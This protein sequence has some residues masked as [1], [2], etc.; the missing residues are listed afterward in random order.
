MDVAIISTLLAVLIATGQ[1]SGGQA[2]EAVY[3]VVLQDQRCGGRGAAG[4]RGDRPVLQQERVNPAAQPWW[5]FAPPPALEER[6]PTMMPGLRAEFLREFLRISRVKSRWNQQLA[7]QLGADVISQSELERM[8]KSA[9]IW[10]AFFA[11]FPSASALVELSEVAV[12]SDNGTAMVYCGASTN[13][14]AGRGFLVM[15]RYRDGSWIP[16]VWQELW[17]A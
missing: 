14:L 5:R 2:R 11:R 7:G 4:A 13:A 17:Q 16:V 6:L 8:G 12:D 9:W 15:L 3:R 1:S 10:D